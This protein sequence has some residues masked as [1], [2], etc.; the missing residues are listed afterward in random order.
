MVDRKVDEFRISS[1]A[2]DLTITCC[3]CLSLCLCLWFNCPLFYLRLLYLYLC[4]GCPHFCL[5]L[6]SALRLS[7]FLFVFA[8]FISV[9]ICQLFCLRLLYL[10]L[11]LSCLFFNLRQLSMLILGLFALLFV[12][13]TIA[14]AW[15]N[16]SFVYIC[17]LCLYLGY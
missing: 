14:C 13:V 6:L 10:W 5:H 12:F 4:L 7:T 9:P 8:I 11:C 1:I 16:G 2:I 17:F 15:F 3:H